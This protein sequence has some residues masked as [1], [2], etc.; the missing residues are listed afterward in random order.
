MYSALVIEIKIICCFLLY[1]NAT[2]LL[3]KKQDF[4]TDLQ[5]FGLPAKLLLP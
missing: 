2:F 5:F 3:I 4:I 1:K